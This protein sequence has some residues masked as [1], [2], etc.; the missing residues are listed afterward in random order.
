[1]V[2]SF[3]LQKYCWRSSIIT[4]AGHFWASQ[5]VGRGCGVAE[6]PGEQE[7]TIVPVR[8]CCRGI[9]ERRNHGGVSVGVKFRTISRK[10]QL[11]EN[12]PS[13]ARALRL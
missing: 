8:M 5:L 9:R 13:R 10:E 4:A 7:T 2:S 11:S 12:A 6:S 3:T 1:M